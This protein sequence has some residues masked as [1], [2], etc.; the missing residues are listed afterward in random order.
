MGGWG[1]EES[2][3][4]YTVLYA[5]IYF[6]RWMRKLDAAEVAIST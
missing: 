4:N 6:S 2:F 5:Q 3:S 1:N